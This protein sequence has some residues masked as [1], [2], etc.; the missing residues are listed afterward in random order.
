MAGI[1]RWIGS[2]LL[3]LAVS[4][5]FAAP[6]NDAAGPDDMTRVVEANNVFALQLY[7]RLS[8]SQTD[9]C[10]SPCSLY[11]A[12]AML[13]GGAEGITAGQLSH[14]L[15]LDPAE[16]NVH[17][18]LRLAVSGLQADA[19]RQGY[20]VQVENVVFGQ[21][22]ARFD[23]SYLRLL[24][25]CYDATL[26]RV[27]F[28]SDPGAAQDRLDRWLRKNGAGRLRELLSPG[29]ID[30]YT[31]CV[32]INTVRMKIHPAE[33][34]PAAPSE[35]EPH[36]PVASEHDAQPSDADQAAPPL[37]LVL[38][39][40]MTQAP[41]TEEALPNTDPTW[42]QVAGEVPLARGLLTQ[43]DMQAVLEEM[44]MTDAFT[45]AADFSSIASDSGLYIS[46]VLHGAWLQE[47]DGGTE[48]VA[49]TLIVVSLHENV[50]PVLTVLP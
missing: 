49:A 14:T 28:L 30:E 9:L 47:K 1:Q 23:K 3:A 24:Q 18:G 15:Q 29:L 19:R 2:L 4:A 6:I 20:T 27:D 5:A 31:Q 36:P 25:T 39:L 34:L 16:D 26:H 46:R 50:G 42:R 13:E 22:N 35:Q 8:E 43:L 7:D 12:L 40:T 10:F 38:F 45:K 17:Q 11:E 33:A 48:A 41:S 21:A 37:S 32:L 44:K